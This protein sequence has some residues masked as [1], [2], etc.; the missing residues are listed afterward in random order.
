[1]QFRKLFSTSG[2]IVAGALLI[3]INLLAGLTFKSSRID[4][5]ENQLY[6][7]SQ[8]TKNIL[9][10]IEEPINLRFYFSEK[11]LV[12]IPGIMSY[13]RRVKELLAEYQE[14]S[15]GG[16]TLTVTDPEPFSDEEDNAVQYGL[17]GVPID[18][19]GSLA[20]FGLVGINDTDDEEV[21]AFF[22]PD[23]EE[24]LEYDIT[25]LVN[26][27]ASPKKQTVGLISSLP[28][29]GG[30]NSANP[31]MPPQ[32]HANQEWVILS[33][34]K[35]LFDVRKLDTDMEKMPDDINVLMLVHPK[36]LA[37]KTL[38]AIDQFVLNGGHTIVFVDP[39]SEADTPATDP[40][41]PMSA[42]T[43]PRHSDLPKLFDAWGIELVS[44]QLAADRLSAT[45]VNANASGRP[46]AMDYVVWLSLTE[47]NFNTDDFVTGELKTISMGTPGILRKKDGAETNFT[48]L[49]E[50]SEQGMEIPTSRVQFGPNPAALLREYRPGGEKLVLAARIDGIVK[51][52]FPDGAP[53]GVSSDNVLTESKEAV[54][55]IIVADTDVLGDQFWVNKQNFFGQSIIMPRANN[56]TLLINAIDNLSGSNDLI[57]LR[58]RGK[59]ARPFD[60]VIELKR[61][62]EQKFR[63]K[64]K[65]LQ[66]KL[67]EAEQKL[68]EL[69]RKKDGGSNMILSSEQKREIE[70]FRSQQVQTRKELRNVQHEL[71]KN[72]ESLGTTLKVINIGL[73]PFLIIIIA[74]GLG[75]YRMRKLS[76]A[77]SV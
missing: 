26:K 28:I 65:A 15:D 74:T 73:I 17:Q 46:Q 68:S 41:N 2:L 5:T 1:M 52:A 66:E 10:N 50:T 7:L 21:V 67:R 47:K 29:D 27:L 48:P 23:K 43:A 12:G 37:D 75:I 16:I 6:T 60:K 25:K 58:S 49:V 54:N 77:A 31:F 13:G 4:L 32:Q 11:L 40:Q 14:L 76:A 20:Y 9:E 55:L 51:T 72:I 42:M 61:D 33:Q 62:A 70:K 30:G 8:G 44:G 38:F 35:Q 45:R 39:Y 22:Q 56:D 18:T 71:G 64:E 59:S 24:S 57:S 53:D 36:N 63:E 34:L 3:I 69:Q 19:A